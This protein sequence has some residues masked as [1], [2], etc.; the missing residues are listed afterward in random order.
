MKAQKHTLLIV[1]DD[2]DA[3]FLAQHTFQRLGS[4]YKI[5]LAASGDEAIAYLKGEG[6]FADRTKFEFP[7]Y[8]LT[9]LKMEP[10]DGFH[11]L[12]FIK[13]N[14]ALSIIPVVMLSSSEDHDDI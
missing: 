3:R 11:L 14:P 2:D 4:K 7:A 12:Q 1:D 13:D 8:I 10:G 6:K 5:Q 9:D